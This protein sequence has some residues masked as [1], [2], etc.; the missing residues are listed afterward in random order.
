M[1]HPNTTPRFILSPRADALRLAYHP[2]LVEL[3]LPLGFSALP[4][5]ER[6]RIVEIEL[7]RAVAVA[8]DVIDRDR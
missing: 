8:A 4:P 3:R 2:A 6:K 7:N 5:T 1:P